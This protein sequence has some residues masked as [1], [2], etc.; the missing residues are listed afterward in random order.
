MLKVKHVINYFFAMRSWELKS[1]SDPSAWSQAWVASAIWDGNI[2][3]MCSG[4]I[5]FRYSR[6]APQHSQNPW[7]AG[8]GYTFKDIHPVRAPLHSIM[9][10]WGQQTLGYH[11]C[12]FYYLVLS[13]VCISQWQVKR[14]VGIF[15]GIKYI[16]F[17]TYKYGCGYILYICVQTLKWKM[18]SAN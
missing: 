16:R 10:L 18:P 15:L 17:H 5:L 7:A 13:T 4:R 14:Y 1:L 3:V 9:N 11:L 6:I 12:C 2:T 8:S